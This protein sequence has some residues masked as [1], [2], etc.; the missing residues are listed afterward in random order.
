MGVAGGAIARRLPE[1]GA[2]DRVGPAIFPRTTTMSTATA[3]P[4][5]LSDY[6][7][8]IGTTLDRRPSLPFLVR[9]VTKLT[10]MLC[11][12]GRWLE[13]RH[14]IGS[15]D[16]YARHLLHKD[17]RNRFVVMSLVWMPGQAT[18]IHDHSCWGAMGMIENSLEEVCYDRKDDGSDPQ[19]AD[20]VQSR[21]SQVGPGTVAYLLPPYE[22]IHRIGN[23]T[24]KPTISL[25]IYGREL[26]EINVFDEATGRVSPMRIKYYPA[27]C[28]AM[29]FSI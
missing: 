11:A 29:P 13:E 18:P 21:H 10:K 4:Y 22:E 5:G 24:G 8:D 2:L 17:P 16:N 1:C 27:D 12:D 15:N 28:G 14:R 6:V 19:R 26:D 7:R 3:A 25:H 9:E 23:N 20:L